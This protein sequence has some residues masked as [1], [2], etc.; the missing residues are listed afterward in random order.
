MRQPMI[1]PL[2]TYR[3]Q[4]HHQFTLEDARKWIDYLKDLGITH[5]YSSPLLQARPKSL[6]GYDIVN[7]SQL[8]DEIGSLDELTSFIGQLKAGKMGMILDIVPNHM[9]MG[10]PRNLW[11]QDILQNGEQSPYAMFFDIDWHPER[12]LLQNKLL[13]PLLPE[14]YGQALENQKIQLSY[15]EGE[16]LLRVSELPL[17][18]HLKS[19][20]L[21][22]E[23]LR[24][25]IHKL[26]PENPDSEDLNRILQDLKTFN[27]AV[28]Q[29]F[30]ETLNRYFSQNP[31]SLELLNKQLE[32]YN[33][34]KGFPQSFDFLDLFLKEQHYRLSFWRVANYE[35]NYRRFFDITEYAGLRT[36]LKNVFTETHRFIQELCQKE[37][38]DGLRIDHIDGLRNPSDYLSELKTACEREHPLYIVAEKILIHDETLPSSWQVQGTVGYDF[39]NQVNGLFFYQPYQKAL[40]ST[41]QKF[42]DN[43]IK[44]D[45]L[46][47][48]CKKFILE[49]VLYS[50]FHTLNRSLVKIAEKKRDSQDFTQEGL[51]KALADII[52]FFP[53][54][55]TYIGPELNV[56]SVDQEHILKAVKTAKKKNAFNNL[57][58][59]N[60]IQDLL[61][62]TVDIHPSSKED[63]VNFVMRFQQLTGPVMAKG[64]EDTAFYRFFPL[65]SLNEVGADLKASQENSLDFFHKQ[66]LQKMEFWPHTLLATTTHDTKRSEDVRARLNVLS[67]L[68]KEWKKALT[69]WSHLNKRHLLENVPDSSEEYFLY[70]TLIGSWPLTPMNAEEHECYIE[71]IKSCMQKSVKEAKIHSSWINPQEDHDQAINRFIENILRNDKKNLFL[72]NFKKF[73]PRISCFGMLNSLS[74]LILKLT[75]PGVPDV[76]QGNEL[77]DFSLV[78]PDNR[79]A[80]DYE[81][82]KNDLDE[83]KKNS[84]SIETH[85]NSP[86]SGKIKLFLTHHLLQ[87]RKAHPLLFTKGLYLPLKVQGPLAGHLVAF[88]RF[89]DKQALLVITSRFFSFLMKDFQTP[90][91]ENLWKD[92]T[93]EISEELA[94]YSFTDL[95]TKKRM[96]QQGLKL[97]LEEVFASFPMAVLVSQI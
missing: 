53:V 49:N 91:K 89:T 24:E 76:Y 48:L 87:Y 95:L 71:R 29:K 41:Y 14:P 11:W 13:L 38:L 4:F 51:R 16:F 3:L 96:S 57:G 74:Q 81:K 80:V 32:V 50:E 9:L 83:I 12:E 30:I 22:L 86:E 94:H 54:Y 7:H 88:A 68:P 75:S 67:E 25:Q 17:K 97:S 61:L 82:R 5:L 28:N 36:E 34:E 77:W 69:R 45:E 62:N 79:R 65:L 84:Y 52:A 55:R 59:F 6:H 64:V 47:Y 93:L 66:N 60:F 72:K 10:H 19:W 58:L 23:P 31:S 18:T 85:I 44:V 27:P 43:F 78:D 37:L 92:T 56:S 26:S 90:L 2:S 20:L 35:I 33:G 8:N 40:L 73:M 46:I 42:T 1:I 70:Q 21:I 39:L 63:H 15:H